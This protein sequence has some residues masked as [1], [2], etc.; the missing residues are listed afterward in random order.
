LDQQDYKTLDNPMIKTLTVAHR[1]W[2]VK[3]KIESLIEKCSIQ[4]ISKFRYYTYYGQ[5]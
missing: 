1:H 2:L 3:H 5:G 4:C